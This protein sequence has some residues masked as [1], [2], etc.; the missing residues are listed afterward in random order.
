[1]NI[2]EASLL[3]KISRNTISIWFSRQAK[4][5]NAIRVTQSTSG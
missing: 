4:T 3:F 5:G 2:S 1:M